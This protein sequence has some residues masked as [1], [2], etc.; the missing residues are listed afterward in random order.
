VEKCRFGAFRPDN[1]KTEFGD[2]FINLSRSSLDN[3][4]IY[5]SDWNAFWQAGIAAISTR[6][7]D[8]LCVASCRELL[9]VNEGHANDF[10]ASWNP[11]LGYV[12]IDLKKVLGCRS[13]STRACNKTPADDYYKNTAD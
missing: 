12:I 5:Y 6:Q 9:D 13:S 10:C 11:R 2:N 3:L 8:D 7:A 1:F 4:S